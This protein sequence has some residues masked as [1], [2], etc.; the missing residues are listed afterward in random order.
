M[1]EKKTD[2]SAGDKAAAFAKNQLL[3][4]TKYVHRR[5]LLNALLKEDKTYTLEQVDGLIQKFMEGK[6]K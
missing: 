3:G 2:K 6:V 1:K 5:D 4:S